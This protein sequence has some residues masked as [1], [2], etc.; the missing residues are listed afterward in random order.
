MSVLGVIAIFF[1][2]K[3]VNLFPIKRKIPPARQ[4]ATEEDKEKIDKIW[5]SRYQNIPNKFFGHGCIEKF[6]H[7]ISGTSKIE[8]NSIEELCDWLLGCRYI[9]DPIKKG[10]RDHW[11]HP[12]EFEYE[13]S[14]DCEDYALW[15]W[16]KLKEMRYHAEFTVGKW[17]HADGRI[18]TH[19]WVILY[20]GNDTYVLETTGK[21]RERII[22]PIKQAK[23]EYIPFAAVDTQLRKKVYN[24]IVHWLRILASK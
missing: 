11:S 13:R 24:G 21:S 4:V 5:E 16:R 17:V 19:A 14:G 10:V 3:L 18:G 6:E 9:P 8:I 1:I 12:D 23:F 20:R 15:T 22:K 2:H 7:Y